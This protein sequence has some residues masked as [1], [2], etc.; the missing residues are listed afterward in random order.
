MSDAENRTDP[1]KPSAGDWAHTAAKATLA[2]IP[3][4]GGPA[5]ELFGAVIVPPLTRRRDEWI[6]ALADGLRALEARVEGFTVG[7]LADN[8]AFVSAVMQASQAAVRTHQQAKRE[9]LRNAV[10]NVAVGRAPD[11]DRQAMFLGWVD[12]FTP[13]HLRLLRVFHDPRAALDRMPGVGA[14]SLGQLIERAFPELR[15]QRAFYD[16]VWRDLYA[17][18]LTNTESLH[19]MMTGGGLLERRTTEL[20]DAF[21]AFIAAPPEAAG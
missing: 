7:A 3:V 5:A 6:R 1:L 9:A 10:L 11:E 20:G 15:G 2:A 4:A 21:L 12:A 13:W 14:G 19:T 18:G 16:Q 17:H 8:E